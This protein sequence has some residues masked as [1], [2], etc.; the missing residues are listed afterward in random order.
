SITMSRLSLVILIVSAFALAE[1]YAQDVTAQL[2]AKL[3]PIISPLND[4]LNDPEEAS[5]AL[6][7][8]L[9][10]DLNETVKKL[11]DA[12]AKGKGVR[13]QGLEKVTE[14]TRKIMDLLPK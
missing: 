4:F 5:T 14:L 10:T 13:E 1:V 8:A 9:K 12:A 11:E 7:Q 3:Q 6:L 2:Q